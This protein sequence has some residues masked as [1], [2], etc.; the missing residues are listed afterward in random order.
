MCLFQGGINEDAVTIIVEPD[1]ASFWCEQET[2]SKPDFLKYRREGIHMG[3]NWGG[4]C[5]ITFILLICFINRSQCVL[6][7]IYINMT[8]SVTICKN[9]TYLTVKF[10]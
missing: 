2:S 5:G 6:P 1:A 8:L 7:V 9:T 10:N 4:A 3:V